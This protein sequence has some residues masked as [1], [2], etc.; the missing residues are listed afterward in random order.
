MGSGHKAKQG[1]FHP[2][3][4]K[5]IL[6]C[7]S[8]STG[9]DCLERLW[10][11]FSLELFKTC[12]SGVVGLNDLTG[13]F[14]PQPFCNSLKN[15]IP[16]NEARIC[17]QLFICKSELGLCL[18]ALLCPSKKLITFPQM[19]S[20]KGNNQQ[21]ENL[22][23]LKQKINQPG[24]V[25]GLTPFRAVSLPASLHLPKDRVSRTSVP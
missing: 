5:I 24:G 18:E 12:L 4:R 21:N 6:S 11:S 8:D 9:A 2:N 17:L 7:E 20:L 10:S 14:Q 13:S 3:M 15:S 23:E 22:N 1:K 25:N 16:I 19:P